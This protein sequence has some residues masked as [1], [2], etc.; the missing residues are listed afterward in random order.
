MKNRFLFMVIPVICALVALTGFFVAAQQPMKNQSE[1]LD[2]RVDLLEQRLGGRES[3]TLE[4]QAVGETARM[5]M[6]SFES[7]LDFIKIVVT[8]VSVVVALFVAGVGFFGIREIHHVTKPL[9]RLTKEL[10]EEHGKLQEAVQG[11]RNNLAKVQEELTTLQDQAKKNMI[12]LKTAEESAQKNSQGLERVVAAFLYAYGGRSPDDYREALKEVDKVIEVIKPP[13]QNILA[14]AYR[15][16][17]YVLKRTIGPRE[18][19]NSVECSLNHDP[20]NVRSLY[21]AAC[22]AALIGEKAKWIS[23][24]ADATTREPALQ[25]RAI[26]DGDFVSVKDDPEFKRLTGQG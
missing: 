4:V 21:N 10:K 18:A 7:K 9:R 13:D 16:Q 3:S 22:Y 2:R 8:I 20:D 24:L 15:I 6:A 23:F 11:E 12:A 25:N 5:L 1:K 26:E 17:A 14:W 19:L